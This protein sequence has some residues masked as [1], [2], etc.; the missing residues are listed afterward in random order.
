MMEAYLRAFVNLEQNDW[1]RLLLIVEFANINT[2]NTSTGHILFK[3]NYDYYFKI[4]FEE[5]I[6]L[7]S[8]SRSANKLAKKLKEPIEICC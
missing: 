5:D 7:R 2:K 6:D 8:K 1:A 4:F 3:L